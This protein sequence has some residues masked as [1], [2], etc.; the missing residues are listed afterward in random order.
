MAQSKRLDKEFA[1][2][3]TSVIN[4]LWVNRLL[5]IL[6]ARIGGIEGKAADFDEAAASLVS[7]GLDRINEALIPA[8]DRLRELTELGFLIAA[9]SSEVEIEVGVPTLW[10]IPEGGQREFFTPSPFVALTRD[11]TPD[12]YAIV[13]TISYDAEHGE[14]VG[15]PLS[16]AGNPGPHSD[17]TIGALAGSTIAQLTLVGAAEDARDEAVDARDDAVDAMTDVAAAAEE[18]DD[19]LEIVQELSATY[20]IMWWGARMT[21]PPLSGAGHA[22]VGSQYL[23]IS[24]TPAVV[25]VWTGSSW[26]PTVTIALGGIRRQDYTATAGPDLQGPFVVGGG[27]TVGDVFVNGTLLDDSAVVFTPGVSGEFDVIPTLTPGDALSFRGYM[28]NDTVDSYTKAESDALYLKVADTGVRGRLIAAAATLSLAQDQLGIST[29]GKTLVAMASAAALLVNL[30]V[31]TYVSANIFNKASAA[32][33]RTELAVPTAANAALTG[34][35][36]APTAAPGTNTT[37]ISTTAFVQ[38][39]VAALVASSPSTLDTL[40]ELAAALGNDPNFATTIVT[41]LGLKADAAA[42]NASNLTTGTVPNARL[43]AR[44]QTNAILVTNLDTIVEN[45][46]YRFQ[47]AATGNPGGLNGYLEHIRWDANSQVQVVYDTG[48][49]VVWFRRMTGAAWGAWIRQYGTL[50]ELL[51]LTASA[52]DFR[53]NT[54]DK[55]LDTDGVWAAAA[56]VNLGATLTGNLSLD[57]STF[58]K[59]YGTATG[60][61]TFNAASNLKDQTGTIEITASGGDRTVSF[62][63]SAFATPNNASL[64]TITSGTTVLFSYA[65]TQAGKC[66]LARVGTVS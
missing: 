44:L 19:A 28:S 57:F 22:V 17:W 42:L 26:A 54:A 46:W 45:G 58:L 21:A 62:N 1:L 59:A 60:N 4:D 34:V 63:T 14:F 41:A 52:S 25:R 56:P 32:A 55:V 30:G 50:V 66:L 13:Q 9:S 43:P 24:D 2:S 20:S 61:I 33:I 35:P 23:D 40:N 31:D 29:Y 49:D 36:T 18:V 8:I 47:A 64:G 3:R 37:Q 12:D 48:T 53:A 65:K 39:A 5:T 38:A 6:E 51:A 11:A 16:F 10:V 7:L 27:F 15:T